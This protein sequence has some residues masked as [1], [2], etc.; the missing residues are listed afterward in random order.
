MISSFFRTR[1]AAPFRFAAAL[2]LASGLLALAGLPA[3]AA[4]AK[5]KPA[6]TAA[7]TAAASPGQ[8]Q[9]MLLETAGKWQAFASQHIGDLENAASCFAL[10][11]AVD[12][13]QSVLEIRPDLIA[14]DLHPD[15]Y[16]TRLAVR[17]AQELGVPAVGV[18]HHHAHVA[19]VMAEHRVSEPVLGL[20][21]DGVGLGT[22]GSAWGGELLQVDA[23]GFVRLAHL[24]DVRLPGGDRAAREPWRVA[25]SVLHRLGRSDEIARR[26]AFPA[27]ATVATMLERGF[28]CPATSS[29]GRWFDA[30]AGLLGV[31]HHQG[32]E[33]Q[34]PMQLEALAQAYGRLAP[35]EDGW[36]IEDRQLDLLPLMARLAAETDSGRGAALFHATLIAA[37]AA[38]TVAAA[39]ASGIRTVVFG[40]GCFM[41]RILSTGLRDELAAAGL[42]VLEAEQAPANDGGIALGQ[43][44]AAALAHH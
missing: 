5:P 4:P 24:A 20:A 38:W 33:G 11:A 21:L 2:G 15:F 40:G 8:G 16:S 17:L 30:A 1:D 36:T 12:H 25:A 3:E 31:A 6:A 41:N 10:E 9:A 13:L 32:F 35:L 7:A 37:L 27:T 18:Q 39:R 14:H 43:A 29:L 28:N 26:F 42:N 23:R 22:D 34:A 44:W 19:A